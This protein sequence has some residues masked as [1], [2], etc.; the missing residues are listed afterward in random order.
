VP[1]II[2]DEEFGA[3]YDEQPEQDVEED[4]DTDGDGNE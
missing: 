3:F 2:Y 4:M 1:G